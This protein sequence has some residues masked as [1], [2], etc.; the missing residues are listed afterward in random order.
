MKFAG[1]TFDDGTGLLEQVA[2]GEGIIFALD[3]KVMIG[4]EETEYVLKAGE[5]FHFAKEE[6][7]M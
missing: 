1:R 3:G 7:T 4:Y 2:P 6:N 5:N